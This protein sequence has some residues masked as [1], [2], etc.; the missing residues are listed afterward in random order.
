MGWAE[1]L[2]IFEIEHLAPMAVRNGH[3]SILSDFTTIGN[4][5]TMSTS[6]RLDTMSTSMT[7]CTIGRLPPL[8]GLGLLLAAARPTLVSLPLPMVYPKILLA[9]SSEKQI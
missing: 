3:A 2:S 7:P 1:W 6:M 4:R 8:L 9:L 5:T